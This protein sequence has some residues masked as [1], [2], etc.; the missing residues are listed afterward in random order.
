MSEL[1]VGR[2]ARA[3]RH[4]LGWRQTDVAR[5]ANVSQSRVSTLERGRIDNLSIEALRRILRALDADLVLFVRWRGGEL[6]R[7]LDEGHAGLVGLTASFLERLD[8]DTRLEVSFAASG[9]R[10]S[11]DVL[12]WHAATS[13]LLVAEIKTEVTSVEETLRRHDVKTRLATKV[14]AERFGW[15]ARSV[16]RLLVLPD[17]MTARRRVARHEAVFSRAYP[18]RGDLLR[19]WLRD[20][21]NGVA[22]LLFAPGSRETTVVGRS[23]ARKRVMVPRARTDSAPKRV[24]AAGVGNHESSRD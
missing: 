19:R 16:A 10:G 15:E 7:L 6:D 21:V 3:L 12:A 17:T 8:W 18:L 11:V 2:I 5:R 22:G 24:R 23:V 4:R 9:D 13:T 14:A 1:R 20:P